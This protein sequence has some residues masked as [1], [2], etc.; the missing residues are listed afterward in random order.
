MQGEDAS[1]K[2]PSRNALKFAFVAVIGAL[3]LLFAAAAYLFA[4][5]DPRDHQDRI[6]RLVQE[7]TG[8]TL[9]I[10]G[11]ITL[12][13]WPAL[14]LRLTNVSLTER[15]SDERFLRIES[16]RVAVEIVPLL[17]REIVA[18]D[19]LLSGATLKIVRDAN[20]RL[21]IADLIG[22]EGPPPRFDI[23]GV[24]LERSAV[25]YVDVGSEARYELS[26]LTLAADRLANIA[27]T[28]ITLSFTARDARPDFNVAV[29]A[30]GQ[31]ALDID[32][33]RYALSGAVIN[34]DGRVA[35]LRQFAARVAG[36]AEAHLDVGEFGIARLTM[37]VRGKLREEDLTM[38]LDAGKVSVRENSAVVEPVRAAL[39]LKGPAGQTAINVALPAATVDGQRASA[40][41]A[42]LN[43]ALTRGEHSASATMTSDLAAEFRPFTVDLKA[44]ESR[45]N[46]SG[47]HLPLKGVAG[48]LTG[49]ARVDVAREG[50]Q[51]DF[52]G[53]VGESRVKGHI[54]ASGFAAP[55]YTFAIGID[56]LDIQRYMT[57]LAAS[58]RK[59]GPAAEQAS[60]LEP[61]AQL[62]ATGT[63]TVAVLK[64]GDVSARDVRLEIR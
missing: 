2:E 32:N 4:T 53:V 12:S 26:D 54:K 40:K 35:A 36:D 62:P 10:D 9:H 55:V 56:E 33:R 47:P 8:R 37:S 49:A 43:L 11:E 20:G 15:D 1:R 24:R 60:L 16:A 46:V 17:S 42:K 39:D 64:S 48:V 38:N 27:Q 57:N 51:V 59:P 50:L 63:V 3:L 44:V 29:K 31:L 14:G 41:N 21:N 19:L 5:F 7:K 28:P 22:G 45:F 61:L 34:C 52:G 30:Q 13:F 58:R 23:E 18:S 25:S 6:V